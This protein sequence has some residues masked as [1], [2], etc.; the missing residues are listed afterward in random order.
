MQL[1]GLRDKRLNPASQ[2]RKKLDIYCGS[3]PGYEADATRRASAE[4][5]ISLVAPLGGLASVR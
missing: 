1:K 3:I 5:R 2:G 4:T